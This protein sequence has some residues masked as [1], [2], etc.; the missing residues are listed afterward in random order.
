LATPSIASAAGLRL[1]MRPATST[2][3]TGVAMSSMAA[4]SPARRVAGEYSNISPR[5]K[6]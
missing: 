4:R 6:A 5:T 1:T 3:A 2:I